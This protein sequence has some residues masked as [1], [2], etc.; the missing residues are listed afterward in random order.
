MS[1]LKRLLENLLLTEAHLGKFNMDVFKR[2]KIGY[3][4]LKYL[5]RCNLPELGKGSSRKAFALSTS[6]V[7]KVALPG[8]IE[9]QKGLAQNKAE[10]DVWTDPKTKDAVA[11]IFDFDKKYN[12]LVME[13]ARPYSEDD[14]ALEEELGIPFPSH[15]TVYNVISIMA[16]KETIEDIVEPFQDDGNEEMV[17]SLTEYLK[18]PPKFIKSLAELVK[19]TDIGDLRPQNFGKT[20]DGRIVIIDYGLTREVYDEH[21][22]YYEEE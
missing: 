3:P 6:K 18:N 20:V 8:P 5:R 14:Y 7:L 12:W 15:I 4:A 21:Y 22:R 10:V 9:R 1:N 2:L 17:H 16:G 19:D 13:L 11:K